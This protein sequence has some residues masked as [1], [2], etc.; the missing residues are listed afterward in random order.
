MHHNNNTKILF[1]Q[2]EISIITVVLQ[3]IFGWKWKFE[4]VFLIIY[5]D[6]EWH[7]RG[8][9]ENTRIRNK[10]EKKNKKKVKTCVRGSSWLIRVGIE[11]SILISK[12]L[13]SSLSSISSL[14]RIYQINLYKLIQ[15]LCTKNITFSFLQIIQILYNF[16]RIKVL[17]FSSIT[18]KISI[19]FKNKN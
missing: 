1:H 6:E 5:I 17:Y 15:L 8:P 18:F 19:H 16:I 14:T 13:V 7:R 9:T 10:R 4:S 12:P 3:D 11:S 2:Q